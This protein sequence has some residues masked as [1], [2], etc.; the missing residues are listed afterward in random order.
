MI[1]DCEIGML[2]G[3]DWSLAL[4]R[5][6]NIREKLGYDDNNHEIIGHSLV[7]F[8]GLKEHEL[9]VVNRIIDVFHSKGV[10]FELL[11]TDN[12]FE[13]AKILAE[14]HGLGKVVD[15]SSKLYQDV[16]RKKGV[17]LS[18]Y[19]PRFYR[20]NIE[21]VVQRSVLS[22][23]QHGLFLLTVSSKDLNYYTL[24]QLAKI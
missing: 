19:P 7:Y 11:S 9:E 2:K 24:Q 21:F 5:R 8:D 6:D 12:I 22:Y 3:I 14:I 10:G 15:V 4:Y 17:E 20:E 1:E 18:K 16:A 13:L 23:R